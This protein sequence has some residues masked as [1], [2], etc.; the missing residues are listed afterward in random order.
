MSELD[1]L[2]NIDFE[3]RTVRQTFRQLSIVRVGTSGGLQPFTPIGTYVAAENQSVSTA[4]FGFTTILDAYV[5][6]AL[7]KRC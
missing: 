7:N 4:F 2:A 3:A 6:S 5:I 1:A